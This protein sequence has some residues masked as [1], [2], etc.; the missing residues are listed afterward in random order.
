MCKQSSFYRPYLVGFYDCSHGLNISKEIYCCK[1]KMKS[2]F[3]NLNPADNY[4]YII[5]TV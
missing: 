1:F 4:F 5:Y 2:K 3:E